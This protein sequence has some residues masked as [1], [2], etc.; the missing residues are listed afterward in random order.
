M[1]SSR[2]TLNFTEGSVSFNFTPE[3]ARELKATLVQLAERLKAV[4][5]HPTGGG[6]RPTPQKPIEYQYTGEVFLEV[7]CNPNI[8]PTP[9]SAKILLTLRDERLRIS[10]EVEL[11]RAIE[12]VERY[13][14]QV[15]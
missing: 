8:W 12:D 4:A 13:L 15:G 6:G 14:E 11:T 7:F 2:L 3:A 9:F 5:T 1:S 10:T